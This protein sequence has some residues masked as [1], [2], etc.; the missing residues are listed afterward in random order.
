L[1]DL[2]Q[3]RQRKVLKDLGYNVWLIIFVGLT[4]RLQFLKVKRFL[5]CWNSRTATALF[6]WGF[7]IYEI[8][9]KNTDWIEMGSD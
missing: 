3:N 8:W 1:Y 6:R 9:N 7:F 5:P 2:R 4:R